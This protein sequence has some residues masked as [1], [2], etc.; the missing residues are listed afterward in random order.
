MGW[1][2]GLGS[3]CRVPDAAGCREADTGLR[4]VAVA[5][6]EPRE[7]EVAHVRVVEG[8]EEKVRAV[9]RAP[10]GVV[11]RRQYVLC[12]HYTIIY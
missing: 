12:K 10:Q 2:I 11:W 4:R 9:R 3:H 1:G 5:Q 8:G 7:V 6:A